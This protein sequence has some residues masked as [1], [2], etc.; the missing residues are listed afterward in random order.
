NLLRPYLVLDIN[1]RP[2][3]LNL[4]KENWGKLKEKIG[5]LTEDADY[6]TVTHDGFV[7]IFTMK[8]LTG[9]KIYQIMRIQLYRDNGSSGGGTHGLSEKGLE[10]RLSRYKFLKV[11]K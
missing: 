9:A 6:W 5:D 11:K 8:K 10:V 1:A 4:D 3:H 7:T 2:P